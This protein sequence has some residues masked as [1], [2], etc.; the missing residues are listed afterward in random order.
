MEYLSLKIKKK[1]KEI[2]NFDALGTD[3]IY[4]TKS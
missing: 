4:S 2:L 1:K 3:I